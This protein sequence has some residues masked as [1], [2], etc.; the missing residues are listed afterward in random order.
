[1]S[2]TTGR[3]IH[4]RHISA[5]ASSPGDYK[6]GWNYTLMADGT[7]MN[8]TT[9]TANATVSIDVAVWKSTPAIVLLDITGGTIEIGGHEYDVRIGYA[10]YSTEHGVMR[11]GALVS[12]DLDNILKL[13][14]YGNASEGAELPMQAGQ[15]IDM[16]FDSNPSGN[17][18]EGWA[19]TL[20]GTVKAG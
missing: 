9:S 4:E 14:L 18:L 12:D 13:K 17:G 11:L 8:G 16:S 7:A 6:P 1:V 15:S 5:N 20:E 10:I 2:K 3:E 19:L